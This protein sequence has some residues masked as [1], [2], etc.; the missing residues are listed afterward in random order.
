MDY[1]AIVPAATL[2]LGGLIGYASSR[3]S[4]QSI[5]KN[6]EDWEKT[7]DLKFSS[8][9]IKIDSLTSNLGIHQQNSLS[10]LATHT[11]EISQLKQ[12]L[13]KLESKLDSISK[14]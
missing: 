13:S 3:E 14:E 8:L 11:A 10:T 5:R 2:I 4:Q 12:S 6:L 9:H 7:T 1:S